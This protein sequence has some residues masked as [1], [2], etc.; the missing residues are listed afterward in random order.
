MVAYVLHVNLC[1]ISMPDIS[2][3]AGISRNVGHT[4]RRSQTIRAG[5]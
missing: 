2:I 3:E 5:T 1:P 4:I